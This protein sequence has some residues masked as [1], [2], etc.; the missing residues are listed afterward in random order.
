MFGY[1]ADEMVGRSIRTIIPADRH[2]EERKF[3]ERVARGRVHRDETIRIRKD[4]TA[5]DV[6]LT[7]L[8]SST[9]REASL[10]S[11]RS[12]AM[13]QLGSEPKPRCI[14][15][16]QLIELSHEPIFSWDVND[17]IIEWNQGC[18]RLYGFTR[19]EAMSRRCH[20]LLNTVFPE[21]LHDIMMKVTRLGEWTGELLQRTEGPPGGR[22]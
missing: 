1:G 9:R 15:K 16:S 21:P 8:P 18:E 20:D 6:S 12:C 11:P 4:C 2:A 22:R 7:P 5:L 19:A 13:S 3:S 17:G 14:Q 10:V